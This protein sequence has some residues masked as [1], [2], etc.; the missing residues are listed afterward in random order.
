MKTLHP[1]PLLASF[2]LA[3]AA[4]LGC[5]SNVDA[6]PTPEMT[7]ETKRAAEVLPPDADFVA[8]MNV[9]RLQEHGFFDGENALSAE[10]LSGEGGA[11]VRDFLEATGFDPQKDVRE[12]YV[13][14]EGA[15]EGTASLVLYADI[16][17]DRF[18][19]QI[20]AQLEGRL[21]RS[22]YGDL[23]LYELTGADHSLT[24]ALASDDLI[25]AATTPQAVR[26]MIDRLE[27]RGRALAQ[28]AAL[29]RRVEQVQ[30]RG[31]LW[32]AARDVARFRR[33]PQKAAVQ[34]KV[35]RQQKANTQQKSR[36]AGMDRLLRA[37]QDG[38]A[39]FT[40]T[41]GTVDGLVYLD[42]ADGVAPSDL[43]DVTRGLVGAMKASADE[44]EL[45][46]LDQVQVEEQGDEV[47]VAFSLPRAMLSRRQERNAQNTQQ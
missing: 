19:Q 20:E 10:Q 36:P 34:Q 44:E 28:N 5:E 18:R 39:A 22:S 6:P 29:M 3:L 23:T 37:V 13:A 45:R 16:N 33:P 11:R 42:A 7:A 31:D 25:V 27:G 35:N 12:V 8:M 17:R 38:A 32:L 40:V 24:F 41:G 46:A 21:T 47:R 1:A 15:S 43:A 9:R 26:S 2:A 30:G 4:L 14:M